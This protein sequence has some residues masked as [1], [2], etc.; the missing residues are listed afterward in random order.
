MNWL[1]YTPEQLAWIEANCTLPRSQLHADF[2]AQFDRSDISRA[3]LTALCKR[4][5]W[6]TG[7]T[8]Q[9]VKGQASPN[10]GMKGVRVAGCE[11]GWFKKGAP[12]HTKRA[13]GY[14]SI[15]SDGYIKIC[16]DEANPWTGSATRMVHMHRWLWEKTNGPV[17]EGHRLKCLDGN[18]QNTNP[19]NWEPVPMALAPRLNGLYGLGY[20]RA[21]PE[22]KPTILAI[23]KL[24]HA[25]R[26]AKSNG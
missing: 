1:R 25:V 2:C 17:P 14:Q 12:S 5:R 3:N 26:T 16:I 19:A 4:N 9:F 10:A 15:D 22:I 20:D 7:R 11:K 13:I 8:G 21:E 24:E 23:A 18:K 6:L